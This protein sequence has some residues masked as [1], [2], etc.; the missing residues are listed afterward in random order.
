M[1]I[2]NI[3]GYKFLPLQ[4]LLSLQTDLTDLARQLNLKGTILLS[5]EGINLSLAGEIDNIHF[6]KKKLTEDKRFSDITFRESFSDFIPFK[7]MKVKIKKEIITMYR[8]EVKPEE[9]RA[10]SISPQHLKQWLDEN[11][12]ITIV[13][14]RNEYEMAYGT[15]ENA[16]NL[17]LDDF[18]EFP[19]K[20]AQLEKHKPIVMFCTGGIRCEKAALHLL[21]NGFE[22]VY[23]LD[24]GI[25]N[26]FKEVGG[27]HYQGDCF[28]FDERV[29]L[30]PELQVKE[31]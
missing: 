23:Q 27:A 11:K 14:T 7:R 30:D 16:V 31:K 17:H 10:P 22:E 4:D 6:F 26:Y 20:S 13:D 8:D 9:N 1:R 5:D 15:F 12:E 25:L 3:A 28:V 24:G 21:Q 18:S 29:A 2:L 19:E